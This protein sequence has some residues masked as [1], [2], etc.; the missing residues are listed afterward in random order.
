MLKKKGKEERARGPD[1]A[2]TKA[3]EVED[4]FDFSAMEAEIDKARRKLS[5]VLSKL[6]SRGR[7]NPGIVEDIRVELVDGGKKSAR[8]GDLAQVV[9]KG[10]RTLMILCGDKPVSSQPVKL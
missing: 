2:A 7:F 8:L 1:N 10:G 9:P 5:E 4:P 3:A 6:N